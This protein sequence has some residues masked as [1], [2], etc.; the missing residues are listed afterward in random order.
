L[1][2]TGYSFRVLVLVELNMRPKGHNDKLK[3]SLHQN[4]RRVETEKIMAKEKSK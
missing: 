1:S 4:H 2:E 3:N